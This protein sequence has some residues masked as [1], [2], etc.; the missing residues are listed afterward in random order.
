MIKRRFNV[1]SVSSRVQRF[2]VSVFMPLALL[3][4]QMHAEG[5]V[6]RSETQHFGVT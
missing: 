6:E 3:R 5:W 4:D 2:N 1:I